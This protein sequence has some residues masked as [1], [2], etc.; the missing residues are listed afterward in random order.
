MSTD[1][2]K[3]T[4]Y[5]GERDRSGGRFLADALL[6]AYERHRFEASALLRG[7]EGFGVHH[8][9]QSQR[10]LTLSEDLPLVAV[11]VDTSERIGG[12]MEEIAG[13]TGHGL[14]TLERAR[15]LGGST[16]A[17]AL[18]QQL[19]EET[20][21]TVYLGRR[22]RARG[23]PAFVAVVD[24]LRRHGVA[25]ATA[26]LGVDGTVGG[27]RARARFFSANAEVPVMVIAVGSRAAIAGA[28]SELGE[29]LA[30]PVATLERVRVLKR[31]GRLLDE[32]S[33]LPEQDDD[34][35]QLWQKLSVFCSEAAQS[36]GRPLYLELIRRLRAAGAGGATA[37]RGIWGYHGDHEPHGDRL[38]SLQRH[39]P[40]LTIAVDTPENV[41][42]LF[43]IV[44]ELTA[45]T[46]LVTSELVPAARAE[47]PEVS[48]G[49]L[50]LAR[51][52]H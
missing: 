42:R 52:S 48:R 44:D 6:D 49:T 8:H 47:G 46:G 25:G 34:G 10:L 28:A 37:L 45:H 32:L 33:P 36:G 43:P 27:A 22:E 18:P 4:T 31:D 21:L 17:V 40:V 15:L 12:A 51:W 20:K 7:T 50:R 29:V 3:L 9:L 5:F 35:L 23:R 13:L 14:M 16:G 39:A 30:R 41:R 11:A 19:H 38:L 1:C 24:L 2:L 26:F